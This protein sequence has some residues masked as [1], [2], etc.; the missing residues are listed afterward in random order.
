[1]SIVVSGRMREHLD[2]TERV[3]DRGHATFLPAGLPHSQ[4]FGPEGTR[5]IIFIPRPDWLAYLKD[6]NTQLGP[7]PYACSDAFR[8]LGDRLC[9]E[10]GNPDQFSALAC[11]GLL[12]EMIAQFG[13]LGSAGTTTQKKPPAWLC[14]ARDFMHENVCG[15]LSMAQIAR[16]ASRH[17]IHLAREFRRFFGV[18]VGVYLRQLRVERARQLL[19]N[20]RLSISE[21]ALS[22]GF[23]NHSHF[24]R[25][26]KWR[27]GIT[28]SQYRICSNAPRSVTIALSRSKA[29]VLDK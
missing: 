3:Y 13:R 20:R 7:A 28:P 25:A 10:I 29:V 5:Q 24:C 21:I 27:L 22:C 18:P 8:E 4:T 1:M 23:S 11:E 15:A 26:F 9:R 14:A 19:L 17:E 2:D 6:C 16:A 12:L